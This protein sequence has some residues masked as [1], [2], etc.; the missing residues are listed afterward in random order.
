MTLSNQINDYVSSAG[1][2]SV[3]HSL[4]PGYSMEGLNEQ[5]RLL[6]QAIVPR[7]GTTV[8]N[9]LDN[10]YVPT[11]SEVFTVDLLP[12]NFAQLVAGMIDEQCPDWNIAQKAV[13][14]MYYMVECL[15][16]AQTYRQQQT[17]EKA[18][19]S[20]PSVGVDG[21]LDVGEFKTIIP[22]DPNNN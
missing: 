5:I 12:E 21:S 11:P 4:F 3:N 2:K 17:A 19:K 13:F 9:Y 10:Q 20:Q 14:Y 1:W 8:E 15:K 18:K 6:A 7:L 16:A 22:D